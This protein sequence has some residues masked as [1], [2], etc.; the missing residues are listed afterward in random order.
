MTGAASAEL[1]DAFS[2]TGRG[3]VL[4]VAGIEGTVHI[5]DTLVV[6]DFEARVD[7]IEM[8]DGRSLPADTVGLFFK[9]VGADDCRSFVGRRASFR[10]AG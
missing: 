10:R 1:R 9:S 7:G 6:D 8:I 3:T 2:L 5:G 4:V